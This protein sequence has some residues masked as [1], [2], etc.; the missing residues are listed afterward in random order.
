[1][2]DGIMRVSPASRPEL[3]ARAIVAR[4]REGCLP[5]LQAMGEPAIA[6]ATKAIAALPRL[7]G[8]RVLVEISFV[9]VEDAPGERHQAIRWEIVG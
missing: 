1:M 2:I 6:R 8:R 5:T 7:Y 4:L 9:V 3:V